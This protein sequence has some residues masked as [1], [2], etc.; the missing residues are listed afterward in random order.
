[1]LKNNEKLMVIRYKNYKNYNFFDE[2]KAVICKNGYVWMLKLGK[3]IPVISL[4]NLIESEGHIVLKAPKAEGGMYYLCHI[5]GYMYGNTLPAE[6]PAYYKELENDYNIE[7]D[8][9]WLKIDQ[10]EPLENDVAKKLYLSKNGH[11]LVEIIVK[12]RTTTFYV[13]YKENEVCHGE[14][15]CR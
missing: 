1:M 15:D 13:D 3:N 6:S 8:G 14:A 7:F 5:I 12:T 4:T 11:P 10:L 9:T 2:H